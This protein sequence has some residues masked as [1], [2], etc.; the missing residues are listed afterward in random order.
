MAES[1]ACW[2]CPRNSQSAD[3]ALGIGSNPGLDRWS[4]PNPPKESPVSHHTFPQEIRMEA[5][6]QDDD[7]RRHV[8]RAARRD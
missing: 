8:D 7:V 1:E 2:T 4:R 6:G 5:P 3:L